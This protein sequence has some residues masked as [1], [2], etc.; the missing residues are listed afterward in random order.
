VSGA[1]SDSFLGGLFRTASA[2]NIS[3]R[4]KARGRDPWKPVTPK[5]VKPPKPPKRP[6]KRDQVAELLSL[7]MNLNDIAAEMG[8]SRKAVD[9]HFSAIRKRLGAQAA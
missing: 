2:G 7:D 1:P 8:I 3:R 6:A 4:L 9:H 5:T